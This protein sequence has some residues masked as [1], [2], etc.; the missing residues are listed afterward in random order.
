MGTGQGSNYQSVG[1][2]RAR[3]A[4]DEAVADAFEASGLAR[5]TCDAAFLGMAGVV[6]ESDRNTIVD[7]VAGLGLARRIEVDHDIRIALAGGLAGHEGIA[8]IAGTGSSCYG[9]R[10]DGQDHRAGGWGGLLD[11]VGG[12]YWLGLQ[13]LRAIVRAH[14]GRGRST[15][16]HDALLQA[17]D[18]AEINDL[19]RRTG[20]D[21]LSKGEIAALA[22]L[23]L[24]HAHSGDAI[25]ID[26]VDQ[27]AAEL[28]AMIAA[29][30]RT[31]WGESSWP[32][33]VGVGGL[34]QNARYRTMIDPVPQRPLLA[35]VVGAA[36]LAFAVC[37]IEINER[38]IQNM[39]QTTPPNPHEA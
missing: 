29:V 24:Q 13:G 39:I 27:G 8:L 2:E 23:I 16:L 17:L 26:V 9:R 4:I 28:S 30:K 19:L 1:I 12:G 15:T 7:M 3:M 10:V 18:V 5:S 22:P 21:G 6:T 11:D 32:S 35:P 36:L 20:I 34:L 38:I 14:D 33:V 25:A 31:L 37:G